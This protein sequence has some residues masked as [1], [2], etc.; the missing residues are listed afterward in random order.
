MLLSSAER[1]GVDAEA[2]LLQRPSPRQER[3]GS[4]HGLA[5]CQTSQYHGGGIL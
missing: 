1:R 2:G 5:A 4:V 3:A